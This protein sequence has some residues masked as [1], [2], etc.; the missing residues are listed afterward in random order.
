MDATILIAKDALYKAY[1]E[2]CK[3]SGLGAFS[4]KK[5]GIQL[6]KHYS[7]GKEARGTQGERIWE[8]ITLVKEVALYGSIY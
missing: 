3:E 1:K 8:G 6:I 7:L 2:W 4:K 5:F